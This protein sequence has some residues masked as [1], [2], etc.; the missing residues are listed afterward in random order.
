[1]HENSNKIKALAFHCSIL[2][3][4]VLGFFSRIVNSKME[5]RQF[6]LEITVVKLIDTRL[7]ER[8]STSS[9]FPVFKTG[10]EQCKALHHYRQRFTFPM[11]F[12][13]YN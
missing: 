13:N 5:K 2:L 8:I 7:Q 12:P 10:L 1:M 11:S 9:S 3:F 4:T 6:H